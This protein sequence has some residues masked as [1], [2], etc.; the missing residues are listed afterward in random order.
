LPPEKSSPKN[1]Y[2]QAGVDISAADAVKERIKVI[3]KGASRPEVIGGIGFFGGLF[4]FKGYRDPVLVSSTDSVGTKVILARQMGIFDTVGQDIVN[5]CV[6]DIF[7]GGAEPLFFLDY[8]GLGSLVPSQVEQLVK[9]VATAC[10]AANCALIGGETA[11]LPDLYRPGDFDI[12]GCIVG[13]VERDQ[14]VDGSKIEVGDAV[15]GLMSSG[16]HTNGYTLARKVFKTDEDPSVLNARYADLGS[17]LGEALLA[18]HRN[19]RPVVMPALKHI[20]GMAHITGGGFEGNIPRIL[21]KGLAVRI[22]RSTWQVPPL[23]KLIQKAGRIDD[24]EMF[25]VFNMGVGLTIVTA[26]EHA[27]DIPRL[28]PEAFLIGM[29]VPEDG[30]SRVMLH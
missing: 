1:A 6:N 12:V 2:R 21:P 8:L 13:A 18:I 3:A 30:P 11:Q 17:T 28:I 5:H 22:D 29:V 24:T 10:K 25:Q 9:G 7:V 4:H 19:Y 14:I 16:L 15:F 27:K 20:R 23:F 26:P